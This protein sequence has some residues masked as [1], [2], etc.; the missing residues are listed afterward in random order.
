MT[1]HAGSVRRFRWDGETAVISLVRDDGNTVA[2]MVHG[3]VDERFISQHVV[4]ENGQANLESIVGGQV[5][6]VESA[7]GIVTK[8]TLDTAPRE[9]EGTP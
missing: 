7:R 5:V 2:L 3:M 4:S 1:V 8:L 9:P 6:C